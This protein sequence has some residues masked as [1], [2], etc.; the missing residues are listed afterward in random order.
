MENASKA[1][2][3]ATEI[4]VGILM[5][6]LIASL[7]YL[8]AGYRTEIQENENLKQIY[9]FNIQFERYKESILSPQDV[10]TIYNL[11]KDYNN[12]F[13]LE[14]IKLTVAGGLSKIK[15]DSEFLNADIEYKIN[16]IEYNEE[17][18]V[19]SITIKKVN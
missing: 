7:F 17:G 9:S 16:S 15:N 2:I 6:S 19:K 13:T 5:L 4:L 18:K 10:L 12:K 11:V 1:L 8:F 3:I 14:Q